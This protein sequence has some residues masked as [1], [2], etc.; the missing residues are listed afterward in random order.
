VA[1]P[2]E[3]GPLNAPLTRVL[4]EVWWETRERRWGR[5]VL[6]GRVTKL[7]DGQPRAFS[8][9]R[10]LAALILAASERPAAGTH[11]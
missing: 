9:S 11:R 5:P 10:Q 4:V 3:S 2:K 1:V 8:D 6:R 7:P